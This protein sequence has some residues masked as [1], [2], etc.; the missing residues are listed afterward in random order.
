MSVVR[1]QL[2]WQRSEDPH[3]NP[4]LAIVVDPLRSLAKGT[5]ELKAFRAFP[6][7]YTNPTPNQ[8][9]DGAIVHEEQARLEQ[10]GSCWSSYYELD[11]EYFMSAGARSVLSTLTQQFLWMRTLGTTPSC[12]AEA[13]EQFPA[14]VGEAAA[15][16]GKFRPAGAGGGAGDLP[17]ALLGGARGGRGGGAGGSTR[18]GRGHKL[19]HL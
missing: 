4:F 14:R 19:S 15:R 8:C 9:P 10:W 12:A 11:V 16:L 1:W 13:R 7:E 6:P 18:K 3:G 17:S 2:Q 5:P